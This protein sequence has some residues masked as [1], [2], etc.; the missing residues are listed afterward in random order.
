MSEGK[1]HIEPTPESAKAVFARGLKG[2]IVMLNLLRF[3]DM[4]DYSGAPE[5]APSKP[6]TGAEAYK[7]YMAHATPFVAKIGGELVFAGEG[8]AALIGPTDEVWDSVLLVRYP[9]IEHFFKFASDPEYQ[10][11]VGHRTAALAD[12][13]LV[14]MTP[15]GG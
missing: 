10:K 8:G 6:M 2:P 5:L 9:S 13:R 4:A 12:S 3:R 15:R 1:G 14:P 11:G 7:V